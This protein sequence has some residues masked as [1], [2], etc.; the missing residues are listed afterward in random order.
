M[1]IVEVTPSLLAPSMVIWGSGIEASSAP[2]T[3]ICNSPI[4]VDPIQFGSIY[5]TEHLPASREAFDALDESVDLMFGDL[6]FR[7]SRTGIL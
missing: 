6:N 7:A 5:F 2:T 3:A 4:G 1:G